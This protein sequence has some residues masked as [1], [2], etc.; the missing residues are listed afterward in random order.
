M[1]IVYLFYCLLC[2]LFIHYSMV[3]ILF[4]GLLC[5]LALTDVVRIAG[6]QLS[7]EEIDKILVRAIFLLFTAE[8]MWLCLSVISLEF[9]AHCILRYSHTRAVVR[10]CGNGDDASPPRVIYDLRETVLFRP[11]VNICRPTSFA[12]LFTVSLSFVVCSV[13]YLLV[14]R[15]K[16]KDF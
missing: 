3:H 1:F 11:N 16:P 12:V 14:L 7:T 13:F 5:Y 10:E 6:V 2:L 4:Y 15:I 8:S 9:A